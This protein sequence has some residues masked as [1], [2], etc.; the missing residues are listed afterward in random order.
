MCKGGC[1]LY[2]RGQEKKIFGW[3]NFFTIFYGNKVDFGLK[4]F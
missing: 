4:V 1:A 2:V 3:K